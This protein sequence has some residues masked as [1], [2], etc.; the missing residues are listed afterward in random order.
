MRKKEAF[1]S[2]VKI[3]ILMGKE[4]TCMR[5]KIIQLTERFLSSADKRFIGVPGMER[6]GLGKLLSATGKSASVL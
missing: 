5:R 6:R 2:C 1:L 3:V 4:E